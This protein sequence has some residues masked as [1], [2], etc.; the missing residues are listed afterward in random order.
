MRPLLFGGLLL[1][2]VFGV[3]LMVVPRLI[4]WEKVKT[5]AEEKLSE[6]IHHRVTVGTIAFNLL[7]GIEVKHIRIDNAPGFSPEPLLTDEAAVVQ[8]RLLPLLFGQVAI[9]AIVLDKP[10]LVIEKKADGSYNFSDMLPAK[11]ATDKTTGKKTGAKGLPPIPLE[12]LVSR[13]A[14]SKALL[15]YRDLGKKQ[16]YRSEDFNF[17]LENLSLTGLKP[18]KLDLSADIKALGRAYPV[19]LATEWRFQYAQEAFTLHRALATLPGMRVEVTGEVGKIVSAP[20]LALTGTITVDVQKVLA[21]LLPPDM[22]KKIPPDFQAKGPVVIAW[23]AQ[24]PAK[25]IKKLILSAEN[26]ADLSL[27]WKKLEIPVTITGTL[28][29]AADKATV[30]QSVQL[31]GLVTEVNA[32]VNDLLASRMLSATLAGK[33]DVAQVFSKLLP[34]EIVEKLTAMQVGGTIT[35]Q[36]KTKGAASKPRELSINSQIKF[37]ELSASYQ[38]KALLERMSV[39]VEILPRRIA[40]NKLEASLAGQPMQGGLVLAGLDI[41]DPENFKP[42]TLKAQLTW[43]LSSKLLDLDAVLAFL[44]GKKDA[45][46]AK[47]AEESPAPTPEEDLPEPD[48]RKFLP[49]GLTV[50]GKAA[51]GGVKFG[52]VQLGAVAFSMQQQNRQIDMSGSVRAYQGKI[53]NSTRLDYGKS[54][55]EYR[56]DSEAAEVDLEPLLN[57]IVDTFVAAKLKKPEIISELK[58]KLT[59]RLT[60]TNRL[61]GRGLRAKNAL[62]ALA[63]EGNFSIKAG[64]LRKFGFQ[65]ELAKIF[66]TEKFRQDIPFDHTVLEFTLGGK[67]VKVNKF[68]MESG[69]RGDAGDIRLTAEGKLTFAASFDSFKMQPRLNPR[70]AN[71]LSQ[72]FRQYTEVLKD[73]R[74]WVT[75]P[76]I[77][78]GPMKKPDVKPDWDWIKKQMGSYV[79]RKATS[80]GKEAEK[81]AKKFAEEQKGKSSEEIKNNAAKEL[82]KA[83]EKLKGLDLKKLFH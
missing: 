66:G 47:T 50:K 25:Q 18:A 52:K 55:L 83:K 56:I 75:I 49:A 38:G 59:G 7:R 72:E 40:L 79:Q 76:V 70:A 64:R 69:L 28:G 21:D 77:M 43:E 3:L 82:E 30:I 27:G 51:L 44:P 1:M 17:N 80:A 10:K 5:Q 26:K 35:Y 9:K 19:A 22:Q 53:S 45:K 33:A 31:P 12:L 60:G 42:D 67:K 71:N 54:V 81:K 48:V 16:E 2:V 68:I 23:S 57:D 20:Q 6:L 34:P 62:A 65:E 13:I 29:Y 63:G 78:N 36:V 39:D 37:R 74:G 15:I 73:D 58:D 11:K 61:S 8:Y 41:R 14:I 46:T 32:E 24:G 4:P